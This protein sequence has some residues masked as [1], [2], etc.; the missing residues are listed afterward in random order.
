MTTEAAFAY[1]ILVGICVVLIVVGM[2][3]AHEW[4]G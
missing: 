4:G 3:V 1:G 2:I